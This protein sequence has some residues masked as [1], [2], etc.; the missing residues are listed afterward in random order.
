MMVF[1]RYFLL[2]FGLMMVLFALAQYNDPDPYIWIPIYLIPASLAFLAFSSKFYKHLTVLMVLGYFA[3][4]IYMWP[5]EYVGV[6]FS[7]DYHPSVEAARES[8]GLLMAAVGMLFTLFYAFLNQRSK[9]Q[10]PLRQK[11]D[12]KMLNI[13]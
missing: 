13:K 12:A 4:S 11:V 2:F 6:T 9:P 3:A 10:S 7:M 1:L 5:L 8:L